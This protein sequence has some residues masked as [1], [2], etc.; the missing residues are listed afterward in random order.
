M[1]LENAYFLILIITTLSTYSVASDVF[2]DGSFTGTSTG[3]SIAPFSSIDMAINSCIDTSNSLQNEAVNIY[4]ALGEYTM[5]DW[6]LGQGINTNFAIIG[7]TQSV[8]PQDCQ[9]LPSITFSSGSFTISS[10]TSNIQSNVFKLAGLNLIFQDTTLNPFISI[11]GGY[12]KIILDSV[13]LQGILT[14]GTQ[15]NLQLIAFSN[16]PLILLSNLNIQQQ[17][18]LSFKFSEISQSIS[19]SNSIVTYNQTTIPSVSELE[20]LITV[21]DTATQN[22]L[23]ISV[24][25]INFTCATDFD[26]DAS[27][28]SPFLRALSVNSVSLSSLTIRDCAAELYADFISITSFDSTSISDIFFY[29]NNISTITADRASTMFFNIADSKTFTFSSITVESST[30]NYTETENS[31]DFFYCTTSQTNPSVSLSG[32]QI[33]STQFVGGYSTFF[34][35][36]ITER[37]DSFALSD[38]TLTQSLFDSNAVILISLPSSTDGPPV[39]RWLTVE[40]YWIEGNNFKF[41]YAL[42]LEDTSTSLYF[43]LTN[44]ELFHLSNWTVIDN[45]FG[46]NDDGFGNCMM[47]NNGGFLNIDSMTMTGNTFDG[48]DTMTTVSNPGNFFLRDSLI[49]HNTF[50]WNNFYRDVVLSSKEKSYAVDPNVITEDNYVKRLSRAYFWKNVTVTDNIFTD[51]SALADVALPVVILYNSTISAN[52]FVNQNDQLFIVSDY[53]AQELDLGYYGYVRDN[54]T[55]DWLYSFEPLFLELTTGATP[56]TAG[57]PSG[58]VHL[59]ILE[60]IV[61]SS[62]AMHK[63]TS[64]IV[65]SGLDFEASGIHIYNVSASGFYLDSASSDSDG[66]ITSSTI[67]SC[68]EVSYVRVELCVFQAIRGNGYFFDL[69]DF[70]SDATLIFVSNTIEDF[71]GR[72]ILNLDS[73]VMNKI[74]ISDNVIANLITDTTL[75]VL[76]VQA[77]Q[78]SVYLKNNVV[79]NITISSSETRVDQVNLIM[80]KLIQASNTS[81]ISILDSSFDSTMLITSNDYVRSVFHNC[82]IFLSADAVPLVI[83]NVTFDN[84]S[85]LYEDSVMKLSTSI[86][87]IE[88]CIFSNILTFEPTGMISLTF[89]NLSIIG[90]TFENITGYMKSQGPVLYL[91]VSSNQ[92]STR[93]L[94]ANSTFANILAAQASILY[95]QQ[96]IMTFTVMNSVFI[97]TVVTS[98][99]AFLLDQMQ[100]D[101]FTF[102]NITVGY[103]DTHQFMNAMAPSVVNYASNFSGSFLHI[104]SSVLSSEASLARINDITLDVLANITGYFLTVVSSPSIRL[105]VSEFASP[106]GTSS[107]RLLA[108]TI[109][110]QYGL[111][112]S[113]N[114]WV[115]FS[116]LEFSNY[117]L[118]NTSAILIECSQAGASSILSLNSS[119][120]TQIT[121]TKSSSQTSLIY[122]VGSQHFCSHQLTI[123]SSYF[124]SITSNSNGSALLNLQLPSDSSSTAQD[125]LLINSSTFES[126]SALSGGVLYYASQDPSLTSI[127]IIN[128]QFTQNSAS[129][130]GGALWMDAPALSLFNCLFTD[131]HAGLSG[132]AIFTNVPLDLT[133]LATNLT[134]FSGNSVNVRYGKDI[135]SSPLRL[136]V[137]FDS[138]DLSSQQITIVPNQSPITLFNISSLGLQEVKMTLV[139]YDKFKQ[140]VIDETTPKIV[141]MYVSSSLQS[142]TFTYFNC[143]TAGCLI[144]PSDIQLSGREGETVV[145]R[146]V[147][148]SPLIT[149]EYSFQA[150]LRSCVVGEINS[151]DTGL[152]TPCP[153]GKYSLNLSDESCHVCMEGA[154]CSGGSTIRVSSGYWRANTSSSKVIKCSEETCLGGSEEIECITGYTGP[155]CLQCDLSA[156]YARASGGKCGVCPTSAASNLSALFGF[157]VL[158]ATYTLVFLII[159]INSNRVFYRKLNETGQ[160]SVRMGPFLTAM[161]TYI[162]ILTIIFSLDNEISEQIGL[163]DFIGNPYQL[164]YF[165]SDCALISTGLQIFNAFQWKVAISML[166]PFGYWAFSSVIILILRRLKVN[167]FKGMKAKQIILVAFVG[168]FMLQQPSVIRNLLEFLNCKRLDPDSPNTYME[169][170]LNLQCNTTEYIEYRNRAIIP[171]L[172]FWGFLMPGSIVVILFR[173]RKHLQIERVRVVL[174][175]LVNEYKDKYYYWGIA[176]IILKEMLLLL[177]NVINDDVNLRLM[178][179]AFLFL[180]YCLLIRII[181]PHY[182]HNLHKKEYA[183]MGCITLTALLVLLAKVTLYRGVAKAAI[184]ILGILNTVM[185]LR[186][187]QVF[188]SMS[189]IQHKHRLEK[190]AQYLKCLERRTKSLKTTSRIRI[191]QKSAEGSLRLYVI[192]KGKFEDKKKSDVAPVILVDRDSARSQDETT[193]KIDTPTSGVLANNL[194]YRQ[195]DPEFNIDSMLQN[196]SQLEKEQKEQMNFFL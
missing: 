67:L 195:F 116:D 182:N 25:N 143:S 181:N 103:D 72:A 75:L 147:Y 133:A 32:L 101:N 77:L 141:S 132:G 11:T 104:Q 124:S 95:V 28:L 169:T 121:L 59:Y 164:I 94:L 192:E 57:V 60:N 31:M 117:G 125:T 100:F 148:Q 68:S 82:L 115:E 134:S 186:F 99:A 96:S 16:I 149:Q 47:Q 5:G 50:I 139:I 151:T 91:K 122:A 160:R 106:P 89:Q 191:H 80:I 140:I 21:S 188:A 157:T 111:L 65:F 85:I 39:I 71:Q 10:T 83:S 176:V 7:D 113:Y 155:L 13:C 142:R 41:C 40:N 43:N 167:V 69:S 18:Y 86:I 92:G 178:L 15:S 135:A 154:N 193:R 35:F 4:I 123:N 78:E 81:S 17:G 64:L 49:S 130:Q 153:A 187:V 9:T 12:Q 63:Q 88:D 119:K 62:N 34:N 118:W 162:Q 144:Q 48:V 145:V 74:E 179:I 26:S 175:S 146:V 129:F 61:I 177:I 184:I 3:S 70:G 30:F 152:C 36:N 126:S 156:N 84:V 56:G 45:T 27:Y 6:S 168:I 127:Q 166:S 76:Q 108:S 97:N 23:A 183:S 73:I 33:I 22:A 53:A 66:L 120:F 90:S 24:S 189:Y 112:H 137:S 174:G 58:Q 55:E 1:V 180:G 170:N 8:L 44:K 105:S 19:I 114:A 42:L 131:N 102:E 150:V 52:H 190:I 14:T 161:T 171:L 110:T 163:A 165:S 29:Q 37:Y 185:T 136:D 158:T 159:T 172:I 87:K 128:S 93:F 196:N 109:T 107:R 51:S 194:S 46:T 2:V 20:G 173:A 79:R 38:I 138:K 98:Q 54:D